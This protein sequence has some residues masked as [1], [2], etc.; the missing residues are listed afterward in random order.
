MPPVTSQGL[1]Q[2]EERVLAALVWW[3]AGH[4]RCCRGRFSTWCHH[5]RASVPSPSPPQVLE[6]AW[7]KLTAA[8]PQAADLD[9][10]IELHEGTLQ[11]GGDMEAGRGGQGC[12]QAGQVLAPPGLGPT[13]QPLPSTRRPSLPACFWTA[14]RR[15]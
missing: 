12:G 1:D 10:V 2:Q 4:W 5:P 13:L 15:R 11:V 14:F 6:P 8:L 7:A 9:A 3:A